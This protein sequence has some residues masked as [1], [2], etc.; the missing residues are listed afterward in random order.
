MPF[1]ITDQRKA[2]GS[3][4]ERRLSGDGG[5]SDAAPRGA[6]RR[7]APEHLEAR[8]QRATVRRRQPQAKEQPVAIGSVVILVRRARVIDDVVAEELEVAGLQFHG[9][10]ELLADGGM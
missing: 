9:E 2:I 10:G 1:A 7:G 4:V 5:L 8:G 3:T 6:G